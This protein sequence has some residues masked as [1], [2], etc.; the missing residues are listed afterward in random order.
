MGWR[1]SVLYRRVPGFLLAASGVVLPE[2]PRGQFDSR[3]NSGA[4][5]LLGLARTLHYWTVHAGYGR[6]DVFTGR[7]T[8]M[9]ADLPVCRAGL[10]AGIGEPDVCKIVVVDGIWHL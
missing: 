6:R 10:H 9:D 7:N 1:F 3:R 5:T 4:G 8:S 2:P